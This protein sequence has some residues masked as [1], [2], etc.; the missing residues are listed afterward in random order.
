MRRGAIK[1]LNPEVL[2]DGQRFVL[3]TRLI[4]VVRSSSLRRIRSVV[5]QLD[6]IHHAVDILIAGGMKALSTLW[7]R[8][9]GSYRR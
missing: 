9:A 6:R 5:D 2:H 4:A 3:A 7:G 8:A 1:E